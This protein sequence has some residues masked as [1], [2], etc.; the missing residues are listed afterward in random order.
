MSAGH[1]G[2][3]RG[4]LDIDGQHLDALWLAPVRA[5]A[6]TLVLLHEGLGCIDM[7]KD[8]PA[9]LAAHTGCGALVYTRAGYGGSDPC[10]L[11]RPVDYL[12]PEAVT[13]LPAVLDA[14]GVDTAVLVGHSDGGSI[15][16]LNC[17]LVQDP[18]ILGAV[19]MGAHVFVEDITVSAIEQARD[20]YA[21][22]DLKA[23]LARYHGEQVDAVFRGWNDIWLHPQ[24][25]AWNIEHCL[26]GIRVPLL[27]MQGEGDPY[28]TPA[29]V[30]AICAG[31]GGPATPMLLEHCSH[32]PHLE[33]PEAT[34]AAI[35]D[36]VADREAAA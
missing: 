1:A 17:G 15:A 35:G 34:L 29:Q 25:R 11:P 10:P 31:A 12:Q 4:R 9:R 16:L 32:W 19:T 21:G 13:V 8:F 27:V 3:G 7:W 26:A 20:N 24:F 14:C 36:F 23:R 22:G 5:G 28:G 30:R 6:P 2:S 33:Q 18:R